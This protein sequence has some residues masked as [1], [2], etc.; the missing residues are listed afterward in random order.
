[1]KLRSAQ[2]WTY[3]ETK[4]HKVTINMALVRAI[5]SQRNT[6]H[7]LILPLHPDTEPTKPTANQLPNYRMA[8]NFLNEIA[9]QAFRT[10]DGI[11]PAISPATCQENYSGDL[12]PKATNNKG[13]ITLPPRQVPFSWPDLNPN[14]QRSLPNRQNQQPG[15]ANPVPDP[16][17]SRKRPNSPHPWEFCNKCWEFGA[18][19]SESCNKPP[20]QC[21]ADFKTK[22]NN[23]QKI[24]QT[25]RKHSKRPNSKD[26]TED[27]PSGGKASD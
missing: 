22:R 17:Q 24:H 12:K 18:H 23:L 10:D 25:A 21:P 15:P 9:L 20:I 8:L 27:K 16:E 13:P 5:F 19:Y 3:D 1:M 14:K 6:V 26:E 11:Y 7:K 2:A 4:E